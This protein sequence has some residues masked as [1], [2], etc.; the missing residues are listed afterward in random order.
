MNE[1]YFSSLNDEEVDERIKNLS[2]MQ[3]R[4]YRIFVY[5]FGSRRRA[6]FLALSWLIEQK[7]VWNGNK[8]F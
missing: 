2:P 1:E 6:L 8:I 5:E 4:M 3:D 7:E